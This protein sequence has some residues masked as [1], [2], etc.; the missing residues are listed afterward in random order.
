MFPISGARPIQ[1]WDVFVSPGGPN[2][3]DVANVNPNGTADVIETTG[4][5][6]VISGGNI[7]S[8]SVPIFFE[9]TV[10]D[11]GLGAGFLT[12]VVVQIRVQGTDLD[13][14]S[15]LWNGIAPDDTELL[16]TQA[17]GG[18]G[19]SLNDW[20]F[21]WS[22]LSGNVAENLLTFNALGSSMSLD[23]L[24]VDTKAVA[25]PEANTWLL[26]GLFGIGLSFAARC[27]RRLRT[28]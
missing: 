25:V 4:G 12:D 11:Y 2:P 16:F 27:R 3:P 18:M 15:L 7:Y 13:T 23:R 28:A 22:G 24:A 17:L 1:Q 8:F 14:S 20:K 21:A 6:F 9:V 19:G 10:P 5:A 26:L